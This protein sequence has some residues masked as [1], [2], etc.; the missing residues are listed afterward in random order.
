MARRV[1]RGL[2]GGTALL[3]SAESDHL[4]R[5]P[6]GGV[7]PRSP[8]ATPHR[9]VPTGGRLAATLYRRLVLGFVCKF[10]VD[11]AEPFDFVLQFY[12]FQSS[13]VPFHKNY[14]NGFPCH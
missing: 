9:Q 14:I 6:H 12:V 3:E 8:R 13:S 2:Q 7:R 5:D 11:H 4:C 10:S 1:P